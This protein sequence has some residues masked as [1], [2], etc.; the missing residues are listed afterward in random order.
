MPQSTCPSSAWVIVP[1]TARIAMAMSD[2]PMARLM[3]KRIQRVSNGT[4]MKPPP[5]PRKPA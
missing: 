5:R 1:G 3:S 2:V 4:R